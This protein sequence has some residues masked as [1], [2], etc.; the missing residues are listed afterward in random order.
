MPDFIPPGDD[1]RKTWATAFKTKIATHGAT[2]GLTPAQVAA[3]QGKCDAIIGR[4]DDKTAKKNAWQSS[5][6]AANSGNSADISDLRST[7]AAIKT[8]S[9]YTEAIG[10]DLGIV[11]PADTFDPNTY[12]AELKE[13]I[14]SAPGQVTVNFGKA[15]GNID[16]V[17]VYSR[18]QGTSEWKF[19]ARDTEPP[20]IDTTPLAQAGTPEIREYRIRAVIADVEI[21]D[22]SD[23]QQITVS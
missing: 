7:I 18:R 15:K 22:Y 3:A 6:A 4:I 14:L 10:A 9:G 12:K 1:P 23:T 2:V 19:L 16:G 8:N 13:L 17:N 20:Y 21:G 11:G 5:V